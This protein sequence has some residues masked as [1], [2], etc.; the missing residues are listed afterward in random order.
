M[1]G[2]TEALNAK[3]GQVG[4]ALKQ[5]GKVLAVVFATQQFIKGIHDT[6][7]AMD[8]AGKAAQRLGLSV[9]ALQE[10]QFALKLSGVESGTF[11]TAVGKVAQGINDIDNHKVTDA[12]TAMKAFGVTGKDTAEQALDKLVQGFSALS[13]GPKKTALAIEIFGKAGKELIPLLNSG[14]EGAKAMREEFAKL[15]GGFTAED[16][17]R[18]EAFNDNLTK[19]GV[20]AITECQSASRRNCC[21]RSK[22]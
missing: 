13:D 8:E 7:E 17:K 2:A 20:A 19:I 12:T 10:W 18:A 16:T 5:V 4:N 14:A 3:L 6:I 9:Q 11:A 15:G 21:R 22:A 1:Q